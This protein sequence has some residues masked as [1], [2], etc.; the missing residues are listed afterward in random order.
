M[1]HPLSTLIHQYFSSSS[2]SALRL[3][4]EGVLRATQVDAALWLAGTDKHATPISRYLDPV[5]LENAY[6]NL[7]IEKLEEKKAVMEKKEMEKINFSVPCLSTW[8]EKMVIPLTYYLA[9][10]KPYCNGFRVGRR[11]ILPVCGC[12]GGYESLLSS[13]E[14]GHIYLSDSSDNSLMMPETLKLRDHPLFA[15]RLWDSIPGEVVI[16]LILDVVI[17][18]CVE[19]QPKLKYAV[20][21]LWD[22]SISPRPAGHKDETHRAE[23]FIDGCI[24]DSSPPSFT[25]HFMFHYSATHGRG[26]V[27]ISRFSFIKRTKTVEY[28]PIENVSEMFLTALKECA[29]NGYIPRAIGS[30]LYTSGRDFLQSWDISGINEKFGL[31]L[32]L[33]SFE[34]WNVVPLCEIGEGRMILISE[35]KLVVVKPE[36][37][38][39]PPRCSAAKETPNLNPPAK[40][41][42]VC[43]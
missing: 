7:E 15:M 25:N 22:E 4:I 13:D 10:W 41:Y 8:G 38:K 42:K 21:T 37:V 11:W 9:G 24:E 31:L 18:E 23:A 39:P 26:K 12:D 35:K 14:L 1:L 27:I 33:H 20:F 36:D 40:K 29:V 5:F 43:P 32:G 6:S 3:R 16:I 19:P 17:R 2:P 34:K 28:T 30:T